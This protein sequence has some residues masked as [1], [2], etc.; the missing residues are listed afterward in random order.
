MNLN[1]ILISFVCQ[2]RK[3]D[4]TCNAEIVINVLQELEDKK[5]NSINVIKSTITP[6][7]I[8]DLSEGH[9]KFI[10][11]PEFLTENADFDF[12]NSNLIVWAEIKKSKN[13]LKI[14]YSAYK[15]HKEDH[16]FTSRHKLPFLKYTQIT[17]IKI[18]FLMNY[19]YYFLNLTKIW[20]G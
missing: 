3:F 16:I 17:C 20:M 2:H 11:N 8:S 14:L 18:T 4:G 6:D 1:Q 5:F 13:Y 12:I 9:K 19:I 10:Y 15:M 7:V